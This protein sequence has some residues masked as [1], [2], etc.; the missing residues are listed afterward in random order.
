MT[1]NLEGLTSAQIDAAESMRKSRNNEVLKYTVAAYDHLSTALFVTWFLGPIIGLVLNP[2]Y[3]ATIT[4]SVNSL[5]FVEWF[6]L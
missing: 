4:G 6:T 1:E 2:A 3:L 5:Y